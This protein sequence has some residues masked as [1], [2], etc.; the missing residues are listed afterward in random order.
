MNIQIKQVQI[1][2]PEACD[3]CEGY[4]ETKFTLTI[5]GTFVMMTDDLTEIL[6]Y[7]S[8]HTAVIDYIEES[9]D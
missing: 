3:C 1:Y 8:D 2:E 6:Q 5:E 7:I 9:Y 4:W